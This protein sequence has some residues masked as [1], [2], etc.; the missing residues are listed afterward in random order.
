MAHDPERIWPWKLLTDFVKERRVLDGGNV[1]GEEPQDRKSKTR[2]QEHCPTRRPPGSLLHKLENSFYTDTL[3]FCHLKE[4]VLVDPHSHGHA[5][6]SFPYLGHGTV[7]W[8]K[9][10]QEG[11]RARSVTVS[12]FWNLDF[13]SCKV[14]EL[15]K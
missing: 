15:D 9:P 5:Q 7:P 3:L 4:L 6:C 12:V 10:R 11:R 8:R 2:S 13:H 1:K 14:R